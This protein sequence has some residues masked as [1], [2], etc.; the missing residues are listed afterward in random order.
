MDSGK[1]PGP[2]LARRKTG[3]RKNGLSQG[4]REPGI[5]AIHDPHDGRRSSELFLF[6]PELLRHVGCLGE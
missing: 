6:Q 1:A 4:A 3:F 2:L 5:S